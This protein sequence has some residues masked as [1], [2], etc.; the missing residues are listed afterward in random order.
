MPKDNITNSTTL[1]KSSN[2]GGSY[3][4]TSS[5]TNKAGNHYCH[6]DPDPGAANQNS[7]HY[8]N[9][10]VMRYSVRQTLMIL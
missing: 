8:S 7:Y 4:I 9:T 2:N 10:W 5:G 3:T 1:G 6:R